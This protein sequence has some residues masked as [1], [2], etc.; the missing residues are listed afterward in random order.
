LATLGISDRIA[1]QQPPSCQL[2]EKTKVKMIAEVLFIFWRLTEIVF[3]IPII[4]MLV[5]LPHEQYG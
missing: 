3:L 2:V 4:G 1:S 5:R